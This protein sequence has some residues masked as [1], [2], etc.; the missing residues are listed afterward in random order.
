M[1]LLVQKLNQWFKRTTMRF[2]AY[3]ICVDHCVTYGLFIVLI[4]TGDPIKFFFAHCPP[5]RRKTISLPS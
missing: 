1:A 5:K 4:V 2:L 3:L